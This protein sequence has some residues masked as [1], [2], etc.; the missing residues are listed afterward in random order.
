[1]RPSPNSRA[2][3]LR[4]RAGAFTLIELLLVM[5][6]LPILAFAVYANFNSGFR[7][8]KAANQEVPEEACALFYRRGDADFR[9][10]VR[11]SALPFEGGSSEVAF[12]AGVAAPAELGGDRGLGQVRYFYDDDKKALFREEKNFSEVHKERPGRVTLVLEHVERF[13]LEY[14]AV[15]QQKDVYAWT[16]EWTGRKPEELPLAVR[17][18]FDRSGPAG[19]RT[20]TRTFQ[21]GAGG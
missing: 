8:W 18:S 6:L 7:I 12:C 11:Y 9:N 5:T 3:R 19:N 15:T 20:D 16:E 13:S 21:V 17:F 1:M 4:R 2:E 10:L 14:F